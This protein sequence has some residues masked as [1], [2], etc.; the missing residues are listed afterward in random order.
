[1]KI[2]MYYHINDAKSAKFPTD[3]ITVMYIDTL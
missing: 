1:M 3:S 2:I